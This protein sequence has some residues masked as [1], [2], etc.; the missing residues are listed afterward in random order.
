MSKKSTTKSNSTQ[1]SNVVAT[2]T[3]PEWVQ[4]STQGLQTRING[5]LDAD[6]KSLVP[7]ASALQQQVFASAPNVGAWRSG[8]AQAQGVAA[9]L[10]GQDMTAAP[11]VQSERAASERAA[12]ASA[13]SYAADADP[14]VTA[15]SLLDVNLDRYMNPFLKDVVDTTLTGYDEQAGMQRASAAAAAARGQK[16]SGSGNAI[17]Q[18]LLERGLTQDRAATEAG[19]RSQGFD[20]ATALAMQDL[21]RQ[22]QAALTEAQRMDA[23]SRSNADRYTQNNQFN[24]GEAN[25]VSLDNAGRADATA[26]DNAGRADVAALDSARRAD[27]MTLGNRDSQL[28]IAGLLGD[29]G[30]NAGANERADLGLLSDLGGQQRQIEREGL[31][32]EANLLSLI[33]SLNAQQPYDLYRGQ[34][35]NGTTTGTSKSTTKESDP[36]GA[37]GGI[38]GGLG[39]LASG[40]GSMGATL[41]PL[42]VLSDRRLKADI[43]T[44]GRDGAGRRVVSYR[45]RGEP[46]DMRRIGHIAQEVEKTDPHAIRQVG[47]YK[48]ID[49]GLLGDV[50]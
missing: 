4:S 33:S 26:L 47:K 12:A 38:L 20:R 17:T 19:L 32:A 42:A 30:N 16:F 6:P 48:A 35:T 1:T 24:A 14:R 39:S 46:K 5:L 9:G 18:A 44:E 45:Y 10:L 50:A 15:G 36:L 34:T 29:L 22:T 23:M 13:G 21:D 3:N 28:E 27:T 31:G 43:K 37:A 8:N 7:G 2:P 25:R 11:A 40:L 49:Y 41:G